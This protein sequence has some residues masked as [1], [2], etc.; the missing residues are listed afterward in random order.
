MAAPKRLLSFDEASMR[1][2]GQDISF[3]YQKHVHLFKHKE[4]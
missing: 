1:A 2:F 3:V 4:L